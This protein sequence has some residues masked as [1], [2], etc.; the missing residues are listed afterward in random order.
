MARLKTDHSCFFFEKKL[1]FLFSEEL[2]DIEVELLLC[3]IDG[4]ERWG[5]VEGEDGEGV[6]PSILFVRKEA[7]PMA[8]MSPLAQEQ[9]HFL[10]G[11]RNSTMTTN[12]CVAST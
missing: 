2:D 9:G 12:L 8:R 10:G 5:L 3:F 7:A 4:A 11:S 1:L 6:V